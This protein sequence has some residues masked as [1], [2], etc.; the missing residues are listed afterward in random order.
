MTSLLIRSLLNCKKYQSV[1][2]ASPNVQPVHLVVNPV[3][4]NDTFDNPYTVSQASI[5][6][7]SSEV[8]ELELAS[9]G[10]RIGARCID[11]GLWLF[12]IFIVWAV[13]FT[14]SIIPLLD[15]LDLEKENPFEGT[16][17]EELR[18]PSYAF[19]A[20]SWRHPITYVDLVIGQAIFL[21][22]Q[23]YFLA[24]Y[25]QT[26]GKR[27]QNIVMVDRVTHHRLPFRQLY[28]KRY[29]VFESFSVVSWI[30]DLIFRIVDFIFLFRDDRR[31][32]HD[33]LANTIVVK[34][35]RL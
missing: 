20:D 22:L 17:F 14:I 35:S 29:L 7:S 8:D 28:L 32:I 33:M 24:K 4:M 31:T 19:S 2:F 25:G 10:Q 34:Q 30:L 21:L 26:I 1:E 12:C 18:D 5:E 3:L 16:Y 9:I 27:Q 6:K 15:T 13:I 23:G 11:F